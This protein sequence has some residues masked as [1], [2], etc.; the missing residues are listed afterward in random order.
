MAEPDPSNPNKPA[1]GPSAA[2]AS[3]TGQVSAW[4]WKLPGRLMIFC[5]RCYQRTI[6]P[7]FGPTCRFT[8]TCS[9]YFI[10]AVEK[11]G[12]IRGSWKGMRRILRC[13]PFG[14]SGHDPP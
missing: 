9:S 1:V 4:W 14:G 2:S 8:P 11:Y 7:L 3:E 5:V 10:Q 13:H 6:S 12:A